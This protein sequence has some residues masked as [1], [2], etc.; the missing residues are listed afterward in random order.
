M[1]EAVAL[2][3]ELGP[4][5]GHRL[6][7]LLGQRAALR[8]FE[9]HLGVACAVDLLRQHAAPGAIR[10]KLVAKFGV[11]AATAYRWRD[12]AIDVFV[13]QRGLN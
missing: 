12:E 8:E 3:L 4:E 9:R 1:D 7:K 11:S 10:D 2:A 6:L 13:S 5:K